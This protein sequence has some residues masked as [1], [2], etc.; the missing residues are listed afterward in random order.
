MVD[1]KNYIGYDDI[2]KRGG[3]EIGWLIIK[4]ISAMILSLTREGKLELCITLFR[5]AKP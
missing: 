3:N 4:I 1:Y 5:G 2:I